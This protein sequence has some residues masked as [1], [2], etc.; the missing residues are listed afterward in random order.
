[1]TEPQPKYPGVV[2]HNVYVVELHFKILRE[3]TGEDSRFSLGFDYKSGID[4]GKKTLNALLTVEVKP[5]DT[6]NPAFELRASVGGV[7]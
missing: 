5:P 4:S 2:F 6:A 3:V 7:F 1:M